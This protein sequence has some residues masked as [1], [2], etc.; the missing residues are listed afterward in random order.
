MIDA[1]KII[2]DAVRA[3]GKFVAVRHKLIRVQWPAR[4]HVATR[5]VAEY[6]KVFA[7]PELAIPRVNLLEMPTGFAVVH[8]RG[9]V[10]SANLPPVPTSKALTA[11]AFM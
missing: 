6:L 8:F 9:S 5:L 1:S 4:N 2:H 10:S 7:I 11:N 3:F